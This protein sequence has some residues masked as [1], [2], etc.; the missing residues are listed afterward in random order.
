MK[1]DRKQC[2]SVLIRYS[3]LDGGV[4]IVADTRHWYI[5]REDHIDHIQGECLFPESSLRNTDS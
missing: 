2:G 3:R 4:Q 1:I 5:F